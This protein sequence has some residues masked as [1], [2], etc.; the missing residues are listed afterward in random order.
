MLPKSGPTGPAGLDPDR[1][2]DLRKLARASLEI[3][4]AL[5]QVSPPKGVGSTTVGRISAARAAVQ[6]FLTS[7]LEAR[8]VR[9]TK[10]APLEHGADGWSAE[11]DILVPDLEVKTLGLPLT[12]EVL[13][14]ER[15]SVELGA[16]LS[17][18][19]YGCLDSNDD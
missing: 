6:R 19:S 7:E 10:I 15:Y 18:K 16:D 13:Q 1:P 9:I 17:V 11:A 3:A 14:K 5:G 12:Q 2:D 8:E 4:K